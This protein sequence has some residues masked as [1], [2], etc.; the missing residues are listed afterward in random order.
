MNASLAPFRLQV[1]APNGYTEDWMVT[2]GKQ[3]MQRVQ[4]G[5]QLPKVYSS[6]GESIADQCSS[7]YDR[8]VIVTQ[9]FV[10]IVG[11]YFSR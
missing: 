1:K 8:W 5:V 7:H 2:D 9:Q 6:P 3:F 11:S 4:D 10:Q